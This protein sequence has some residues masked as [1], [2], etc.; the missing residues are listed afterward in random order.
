MVKTTMQKEKKIKKLAEQILYHQNLYYNSKPEIS[1]AKF[2]LLM[3]ELITLDPTHPVIN[4][5]GNDSSTQFAKVKHIMPMNSQAKATQSIEFKKWASDHIYSQYITQY[6]LDGISVELQ[7]LNGRFNRAVSRGN[8]KIGDDITI[9]VRKMNGVPQQVSEQFSGAVRGEIIM[10][11]SVFNKKYSD[12]KNCRNSASGIAKRKDGKGSDDLEII[13]YNSKNLT[14]P[15]SDE[16]SKI[17]WLNKNQFTTV[18]TKIYSSVEEIIQY[19]QEVIDKLRNELDYDI[20]GLV[21]KNN[22]IDWEDME[23]TR[24]KKQIAFKFPPN[25]I[26][27]TVLDVEWSE[28]GSIYTP[29]AVVIPVEIAGSTVQRASLAN[30]G[31]INNLNLKIGSQV[32]IVKRG[33]IIPKIMRVVKNPKNA[34]KIIQPSTCSTCKTKLVNEI[35]RLYC[36]NENCSKRHFHRL[37]KW[38]NKLEIR[39]FGDKLLGQL[40]N[41]GRIKTISH[42]YSLKHEDIMNLENQGKK[43]AERALSNLFSIKEISLPRFIAGFDIEGAG[44]KLINLIVKAGYDSLDKIKDSPLEDLVSVNQIGEILAQKIQEGIKNNYS[45]MNLVLNSGNINIIKEKNQAQRV[46]FEKSFCFTGKLNKITRK[47]AKLLVESNGGEFKSSVTKDLSYLIT[48]TPE[49]ESSKNQKARSLGISILTE[50]EFL[51]LAN[52]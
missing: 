35:T 9:N 30:P 8:G 29:V 49:S 45:E 27:T 39:Y 13:V 50:E 24:P 16:L 31:L 38:L 28:S 33:E 51:N 26:I 20:D 2:D 37:Q 43:S 12:Q 48:N 47:E 46:L 34:K 22:E 40:F 11:H 25:E 41:S 42:L 6:K 5:V 17:D 52:G 21:I 15:F 36:P 18:E 32:I 7:Y 1:D 14:N 3:D 4:L 23:R 44:E 10:L 19:R